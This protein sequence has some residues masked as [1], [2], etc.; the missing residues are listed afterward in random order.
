MSKGRIILIIFLVSIALL[1]GYILVK[2]SDHPFPWSEQLP[3]DMDGDDAQKTPSG[4]PDQIKEQLESLTLEEKVGQMVMVGIDGE[5][6]RDDERR[7]IEENHV[8]GVILFKRNIQNAEQM[9]SLVNEL[10]GVNSANKIPLFLSIDEEGGIVTRMPDELRK[11]PSSGELGEAG[12]S[13]L[14]FQIGNLLGQELKA[15]GLNMNFAPVLDIDSNPDNPV[16]GRRAF[17]KEPGIVSQLGVQTM[18]GIREQNVIPVVKHFPGHGDTS[19]DSHLGLPSL[20][21]DLQKLTDFELKPFAAAIENNA[22]VVMIGH[23]LLSK[24]DPHY[25]ASFSKAVIT[26]LLREKMDFGGVVITDD[27]TMEAV[28][29]HYQL[30]VAAVESIKA[31]GDLVLVCHSLENEKQ[32][33]DAL[34]SAVKEGEIPLS[35]VDESVYRILKLKQQYRLTDDEVESVDVGKINDAIEKLGF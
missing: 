7:I 16:I 10:K 3:S 29:K 18:K 1:A 30:G 32:V 33:L 9:L 12:D 27:L 2:G 23:L 14:S 34:L 6:L 4:K 26:D 17:G 31:G 15:F 20:E 22:E 21:H 25:P 35:R 28:M 19:V 13:E 5:L 24:I 11:L 8:G